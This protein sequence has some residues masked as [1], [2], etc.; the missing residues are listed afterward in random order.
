M[1]KHLEM[2]VWDF[3]KTFYEPQRRRLQAE[4]SKVKYGTLVKQWRQQ[5]GREPIVPA[6]TVMLRDVVR[7][8]VEVDQPISFGGTLNDA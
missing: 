6:G 1:T 8:V 3:Y 5:L 7:V 2:T 4:N